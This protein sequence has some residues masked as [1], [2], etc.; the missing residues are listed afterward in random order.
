MLTVEDQL[1]ALANAL[2]HLKPDGLFAGAFF[3]PRADLIASREIRGSG[4]LWPD[5]YEDPDTGRRVLVSELGRTRPRDQRIE[6]FVRAEHLDERGE[7]VKTEMR[8]LR[9]AYIWPRELEHLLWRAGFALEHL[10][11]DFEGTPF[12]EGG[13][14]I[15]FVARPR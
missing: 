13:D 1:A 3:F 15:V 4:W 10:Y 9:L 8:E 7:V 6:V 5:E 11:G 12:S 14:E 2:R